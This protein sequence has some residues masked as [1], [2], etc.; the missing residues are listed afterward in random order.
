MAQARIM[1]VERFRAKVID[2]KQDQI[3]YQDF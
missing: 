1:F 2:V 3:S